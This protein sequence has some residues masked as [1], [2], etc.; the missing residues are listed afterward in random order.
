MLLAMKFQVVDYHRMINYWNQYTTCWISWKCVNFSASET[1]TVLNDF[2]YNF[3]YALQDR[4]KVS[5]EIN[6]HF[7]TIVTCHFQ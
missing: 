1:H 6:V 4:E 7:F 2:A 3:S 5:T